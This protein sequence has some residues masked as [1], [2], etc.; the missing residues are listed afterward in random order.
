MFYLLYF[1]QEETSIN[2]EFIK[3]EWKS[4]KKGLENKQRKVGKGKNHKKTLKM[5]SHLRVAAINKLV[6]DHD[7]NLEPS[8]RITFKKAKKDARSLKKRSLINKNKT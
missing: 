1:N 4:E 2:I 8:F 7:T 3:E 6:K 5:C